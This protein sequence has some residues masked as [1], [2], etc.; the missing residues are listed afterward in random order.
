MQ[1]ALNKAKESLATFGPATSINVN[2]DGSVD[3]ELSVLMGEEY[4]QR[5]PKLILNVPHLAYS[6]ISI[7]NYYD[8]SIEDVYD[9]SDF[10][11]RRGLAGIVTYPTRAGRT[12]ALTKAIIGRMIAE[13]IEEGS[14]FKPVETVVHL[15]WHPNDI[16]PKK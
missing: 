4:Q 15:H 13:R 16:R 12:R 8:P 5:F 10:N 11:I 3:G 2:S 14:G 1:R 6:W 7:H 9:L